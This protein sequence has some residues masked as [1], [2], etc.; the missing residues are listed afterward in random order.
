MNAKELI[1]LNNKK[2]KELTKENEEYY[3]NMLVYIRTNMTAS[4]QQSEELLMELLDHLIEAQAEGKRAEEVFGDNPSAYCDE[5][6]KQLP[7]EPGKSTLFFIGFLLLQLASIFA[8]IS[9][10]GDIIIHYLRDGN[11]K[12]YLGT[13]VLSFFIIAAIIFLDVFLILKWLQ[14]SIYKVTNKVKDFLTLFFIIT[15]SLIGMV[16]IPKLIPPFGYAIEIGG[17]LYL[18]V[19]GA[20]FIISKWIDRKYHITK[21]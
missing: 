20:A 14:Q 9:G 3:S 10:I 6:L 5:M 8:I 17:F 21:V 16:F 11:Q 4:E 18:I 12:V 2:R 7:K 1:R 19:G 15:L 13:A